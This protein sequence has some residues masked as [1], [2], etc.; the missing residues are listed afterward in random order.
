MHAYASAISKIWLVSIPICGA[1]F[2]MSQCDLDMIV[3]HPLTVTFL[4]LFVRAYSLKRTVVRGGDAKDDPEKGTT[5]V[6][7]VPGEP[8]EDDDEKKSIREI[9]RVGSNEGEVVKEETA[10]ERTR[11][12]EPSVADKLEV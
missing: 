8:A 11:T 4:V 9:S 7:A 3:F 2:I 10:T 5:E 6:S 12:G 1:G